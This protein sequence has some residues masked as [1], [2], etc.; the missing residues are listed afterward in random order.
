MPQ[1]RVNE[2]QG[3]KH[4]RQVETQVQFPLANCQKLTQITS[5]LSLAS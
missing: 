4:K 5:I 3:K 2:E 1:D